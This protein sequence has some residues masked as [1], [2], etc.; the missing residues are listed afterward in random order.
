MFSPANTTEESE[1]DSLMKLDK[2]VRLEAALNEL[3]ILNETLKLALMHA[4]EWCEHLE[5]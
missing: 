5:Q 3:E 1:N 4:K 2:V